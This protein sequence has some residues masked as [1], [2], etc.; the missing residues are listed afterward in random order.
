MAE[1]FFIL[2][3]VAGLAA[4]GMLCLTLAGIVAGKVKV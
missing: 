1:T 4:V 3:K 2:C